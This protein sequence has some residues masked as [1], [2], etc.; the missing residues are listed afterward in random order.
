MVTFQVWYYPFSFDEPDEVKCQVKVCR[1]G[2][3]VEI[4]EYKEILDEKRIE[5]IK[6]EY[7]LKYENCNLSDS[8]LN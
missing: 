6:I 7:R 5:E 4:V 1:N 3:T 8:R 2:A